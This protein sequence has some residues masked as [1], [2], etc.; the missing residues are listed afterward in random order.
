MSKKNKKKHFT[1]KDALREAMVEN[2]FYDGRFASKQF[3]SKKKKN[4]KYACRKGR[5]AYWNFQD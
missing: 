1:K 4:D 2:N 3:K 5:K